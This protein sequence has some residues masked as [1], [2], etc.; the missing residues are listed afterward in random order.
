MRTQISNHTQCIIKNQPRF[1]ACSNFVK[2]LNV[3]RKEKN[4][5]VKYFW[6]AKQFGMSYFM[7]ITKNKKIFY[8]SLS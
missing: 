5:I 4:E 3:H 1:F 6:S 7:R 8:F 2:Y